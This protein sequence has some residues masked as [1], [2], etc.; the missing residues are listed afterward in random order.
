MQPN[1]GRQFVNLGRTLLFWLKKL[2][3]WLSLAVKLVLTWFAVL[4]AGF[5]VG[6]LGGSVG[7][8]A[9]APMVQYTVVPTRELPVEPTADITIRNTPADNR[10]PPALPEFGRPIADN[11]NRPR[12]ASPDLER[13]IGDNRPP[14]EEWSEL[15][16]LVML[17]EAA[18]VASV[19][20]NAVNIIDKIYSRFF[21]RK[22]GMEPPDELKPEHSAVIKNSE[23]ES[24]LVLSK[25]GRELSKVTFDELAERLSNND[26]EYIKTREVVMSRLYEQWEAAYPT[27][28]TEM[29]PIRKTQ[30]KQ[31]IDELT[32]QLGKELDSILTFV[33]KAGLSLD[34]HYR[35]FQDLAKRDNP[36]R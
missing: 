22:T 16:R 23:T 31:R 24:A 13:L 30:L 29:D 15:E 35:R 32:D 19:L 12:P 14:P 11:R 34:A 25:G 8:T 28:V 5:F 27:L 21:E 4:S 10:P 6:S 36:D 17:A 20:G 3:L 18:A 1:W 2:L 26:M 7:P 9:P 33:A